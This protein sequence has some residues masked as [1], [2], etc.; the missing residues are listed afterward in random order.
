LEGNGLLEVLYDGGKKYKITSKGRE[1]L[2]KFNRAED[3][4]L[5]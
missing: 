2:E 4:A 3:V 5:F 1:F